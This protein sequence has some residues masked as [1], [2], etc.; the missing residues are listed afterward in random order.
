MLEPL[1]PPE[2][3]PRPPPP[4]PDPAPAPAPAGV[5]PGLGPRIFVVRRAAPQIPLRP[6]LAPPIPRMQPHVVRPPIPRPLPPVQ[7]P[8]MDILQE[9]LRQQQ[10]LRIQQEAMQNL[11]VPVPAAAAAAAADAPLQPPPH[12]LG[13]APDAPL[14]MPAPGVANPMQAPGV[15]NPMQA[16]GV[17]NPMH[18]PDVAP[19]LVDAVGDAIP[20][21]Q[22][23][24]LQG[25]QL[26]WQRQQH[27]ELQHLQPFMADPLA[28][29]ARPARVGLPAPPGAVQA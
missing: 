18:A 29:G 10:V 11:H 15:A 19:L 2:P 7:A 22:L 3:D 12:A 9:I 28:A 4:P 23:N 5:V 26:Q 17:A 1:P 25:W 13:V 14:P 6:Q 8:P 24:A 20:P 27:Q 21:L 16:P